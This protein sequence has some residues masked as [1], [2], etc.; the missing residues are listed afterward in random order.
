MQFQG[1]D[2]L[3]NINNNIPLFVLLPNMKL[4]TKNIRNKIRVLAA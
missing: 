4:I 1:F 2:W 3:S